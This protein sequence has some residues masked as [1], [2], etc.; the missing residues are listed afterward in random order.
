MTATRST[1]LDPVA[2]EHQ[3]KR[4]KARRLGL[5][6]A[7][8][9]LITVVSAVTP[10]LRD[11]THVLLEAITPNVAGFAHGVAA[12]LGLALMLLGRGLAKRRRVALLSAVALLG[13][14][15]VV[16]V[17]KGLDF[18]E[19]VASAVVAIVLVRSRNLFNE[20]TP[21]ARWTSLARW[22][23]LVIGFAFAYGL[24]GLYLRAS[25]I[26]GLTF[27]RALG[28]VAA[29]LVGMPGPLIIAGRFGRWFP[30]SITGVGAVSIL[31]IAL[32][33]LAP[34]AEA[35]S[36][37]HHATRDKVRHMTD[38]ADGDTLDPFALR[39]D[40]CYV[41]SS[42]GTAAL[43]YRSVNGVGLA[44]GDPFG[45]P[46]R[47]P[48]VIAKFLDRCEAY[49]WRPASIGV[50]GDRLDLWSRLGLRSHYLGDEA[51]IDVCG[52]TLDGRAMRPVRQ[53]VNRTKNHGIT[54]EIYRE[55]TMCPGLRAELC[56]MAHRHRNGEPERGF[57]MALDGL[58]TGRD[59][60]CVVVVGRDEEGA[61]IAFQRYVPCRQGKA[62]SLDAMRRERVG[63]NGVN[64]RLIVEAVL[65]A[66]EHGI[67]EVSLNFAVFKGLIEEGA[68]LRFVQSIEAWFV[69]RLNPYFQIES[70]LTFNAKFHP[71]W[72]PRYLAYRSPGDFV[73][74]GIAAASAE[75]FIP[76]DRRP[77]AIEGAG[78]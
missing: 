45:N 28:E 16:H 54:A 3:R 31:V 32:L 12:I 46:D 21:T 37:H 23:P 13:V 29:R 65:W 36:A 44:S 70:L 71:R 56:A 22:V 53:A 74:T 42:D 40:K 69:R 18:E 68:D 26:P 78:V 48:E 20:P 35:V 62:L 55:G 38:R 51:I 64:E 50:R 7:F 9:G 72:V 14:T 59:G 73:P 43:A 1:V 30:A 15:I 17:V 75:G 57:S 27:P 2:R 41:L 63:P 60:D 52:F 25:H 61:P 5:L 77:A 10:N 24:A 58:L 19:A 47:F 11:R 4:R 6:V 67:D 33:A 49:G 39:S 34:V 66:Q 8:A 76:F